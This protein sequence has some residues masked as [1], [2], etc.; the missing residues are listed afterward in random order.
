MDTASELLFRL[1]H[2]IGHTSAIASVAVVVTLALALGA[3]VLI[4]GLLGLGS[5]PLISA[6]LRWY[7]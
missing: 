5:E 2:R 4:G 7:A 3:I 6:P 1:G